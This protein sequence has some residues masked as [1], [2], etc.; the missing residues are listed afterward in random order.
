[1]CLCKSERGVYRRAEW[2][3][4]G[5]RRTRAG[6]D[7]SLVLGTV[8]WDERDVDGGGVGWSL[9]VPHSWVGNMPNGRS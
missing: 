7:G 6:Q 1:M 4:E 3:A 2:R 8:R 9:R 5:A